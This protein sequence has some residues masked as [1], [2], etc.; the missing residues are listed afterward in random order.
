MEDEDE[1]NKQSGGIGFFGLL[2]VA[3]IILKL[4]GIIDWAWIWVL[5]PIWGG[6][7]LWVILAVLFI[8]FFG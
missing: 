8:W 7:V 3:F 6:M 5:S 4:C 2:G 1:N